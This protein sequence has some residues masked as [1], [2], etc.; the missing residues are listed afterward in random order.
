[1]FLLHRLGRAAFHASRS[2]RKALCCPSRS[3]LHCSSIRY[4]GAS[5]IR[6]TVVLRSPLSATLPNS[7][8]N[9]RARR[10]ATPRPGVPGR[11]GLRG[12]TPI[13]RTRRRCWGPHLYPSAG[14]R[15][16]PSACMERRRGRQRTVQRTFRV[17][18]AGPR[19]GLAGDCL[20]VERLTTRLPNEARCAAWLA[21]RAWRDRWW[22]AAIAMQS[23]ISR[24]VR[25]PM[26]ASR[27]KT[28]HLLVQRGVAL[29]VLCGGNPIDRVPQRRFGIMSAA[30]WVALARSS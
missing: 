11:R 5:A 12:Q 17:R 22:R 7:A 15:S 2:L 20:G 16:A 27:T 6:S 29:P 19:D 3:C 21:L 10:P 13:V 25:S 30:G 9:G 24:T 18:G 4:A 23:A 26:R 14:S 8:V 1:M 28:E